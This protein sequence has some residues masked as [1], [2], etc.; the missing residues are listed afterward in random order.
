MLSAVNL[1]SIDEN[2][3]ERRRRRHRT[4]RQGAEDLR[5]GDSHIPFVAGIA[6]LV[7]NGDVRVE[8]V[9]ESYRSDVIGRL[10]IVAVAGTRNSCDDQ[11]ARAD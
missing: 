11:P 5:L 4:T 1:I 3:G 8:I 10:K 7:A 2:I 9:L 6:R